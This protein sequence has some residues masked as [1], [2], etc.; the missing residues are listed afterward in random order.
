MRS[1]P[2][3]NADRLIFGRPPVKYFLLLKWTIVGRKNSPLKPLY[4]VLIF[5]TLDLTAI[6]IQSCGGA[7]GAAAYNEGRST[8]TATNT[9]VGLFFGFLTLRL[10]V[11]PFKLSVMS[12][13]QSRRFFYGNELVV[14]VVQK[15][16]LP[17]FR[18][19]KH[20]KFSLR[21]LWSQMFA[22]LF[23]RSTVSLNFL[24]DGGVISLLRNHGRMVL[25]VL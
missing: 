5:C 23:V 24:K 12:S 10:Q 16:F 14:I 2:S 15:A 25:M 19:R 20:S 22:F 9:I 3:T 21:L 17:H 18:K 11:L 1:V 13:F 6:I 4:Y 7:S 8:Q